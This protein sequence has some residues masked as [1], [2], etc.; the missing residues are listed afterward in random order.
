MSSKA[1]SRMRGS[2]ELPPAPF[3]LCF[4]SLFGLNR[5]MVTTLSA[6][7]VGP[8]TISS[9]MAEPADSV[10]AVSALHWLDG[11]HLAACCCPSL[12]AFGDCPG[13]GARLVILLEKR[14]RFDRRL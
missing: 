5:L 8:G 9:A 13:I 6:S 3:A 7:G 10:V 4:S 11:Q 14:Q 12:T 2:R 1:T